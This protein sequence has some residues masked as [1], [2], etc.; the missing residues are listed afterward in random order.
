MKIL[1]PV[2][3]VATVDEDCELR[4]DGKD[5]DPDYLDYELNEWDDYSWEEALR[6]HEAHGDEVEIVPVTIGPEE[7]EDGLRRCL[8]K[9]GER[10]IR[11]W[12]E[13]LEGSDPMAVA[14]VIAKVAQRENADLVFAGTLSSDHGFAATGIC[15]AGLL[16]WPHAAVVSRLEVSPASGQVTLHRELEAGLE[17]EA[18]VQFPA[19]L[20]IQLGINEP[21]YAS[22]RGIKQAR[23]KPVEV[24]S[25]SDLGLDDAEVGESGSLSR[26][27]RMFVPERGQ[28]ELI[29]GTVAEQAARIAEIVKA[30]TGGVQ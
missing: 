2:K 16:D 22:L 25:H 5:V 14:R 29:E 13:A 26:V 23:A 6:L 17:E 4:D 1:V 7:A 24:L 19:V 12:D 21:R 9:G 10:A 8:A 3:Q 30:A 18:T 11:V 20:T 27:R 28:A 15:A